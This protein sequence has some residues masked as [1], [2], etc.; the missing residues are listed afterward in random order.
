M[1][2][3]FSVLVF[4][5]SFVFLSSVLLTPVLAKPPFANQPSKPPSPSPTT[6][7]AP[8]RSPTAFAQTR[9]TGG[10][11][12]AC[13]S[14]EK[15]LQTRLAHLIQGANSMLDTFTTIATRVEDFY[16]NK[17]I[18]T[19]KTVPDYDSLFANI[20]DAKAKVETDLVT[21]TH[22]S[23]DFSCTGIDPKGHL[24]QFRI[25]MQEVKKSL[26]EYRIAIKN[27]IVAVHTVASESPTP[28][29]AGVD[30]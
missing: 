10:V 16:Q 3:V 1:Q 27:L 22:N 14:H 26:K 29:Q 13:Q 2:K 28:T 9:L 4:A 6:T 30:K 21:T 25:D 24:A 11:L 5:F 18:P 7:P 19:G 20:H 8:S 15:V 23:D 12:Q 17:V